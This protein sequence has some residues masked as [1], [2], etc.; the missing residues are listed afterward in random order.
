MPLWLDDEDVLDCGF[1]DVQSTALCSLR[2]K[3]NL[4]LCSFTLGRLQAVKAE[5]AD[6]TL[7]VFHPKMEMW[8]TSIPA[9]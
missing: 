6:E 7:K 4:Y 2:G 8:L 1:D 5:Y 3:F 9:F